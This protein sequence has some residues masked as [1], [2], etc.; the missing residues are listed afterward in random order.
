M[1]RED[2]FF[3]EQGRREAPAQPPPHSVPV[4]DEAARYN[5]GGDDDHTYLMTLLNYLQDAMEYASVV[6]LTSKR[7]VDT[8][9]CL[10]IIQN[11][12]GNLPLAIQYAEQVMRDR[13]NI[14]VSAER[15]AAN[16]LQSADVRANAAIDDAATR[17]QQMLEEAQSHADKIIRDAE[18]R[19]RAMIDQTAIKVAAQN[20]ARA[21]VN[22]ARA[23]ANERRLDASAYGEELLL[24]VEKELQ[25]AAEMVRQR[26]QTLDNEQQ[27]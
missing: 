7:L 23:E 3:G 17:S 12:R 26:R 15:A 18:I 10:D 20:D 25:R 27:R 19:A 8:A 11:I 9:M 24:N 1:D 13:E 4:P 22:E 5:E 2:N 16:K 21:I 14:L 6:P